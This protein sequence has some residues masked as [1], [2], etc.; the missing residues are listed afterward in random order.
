M[1]ARPGKTQLKV[2]IQNVHATEKP[3][4]ECGE[5]GHRFINKNLLNIHNKAVHQVALKNF[6]CQFCDFTSTTRA[7]IEAHQ[8]RKHTKERIH[9]QTCGQDFLTDRKLAAHI[10]LEHEGGGSDPNAKNYVC[11]WCDYAGTTQVHL[12]NHVKAVHENVR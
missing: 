2:H 11:D 6:Q 9:C 5:C 8:R 7:L 1:V 12:T 3:I 4:Y 10:R